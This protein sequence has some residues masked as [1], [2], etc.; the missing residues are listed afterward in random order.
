MILNC[1][2]YLLGVCVSYHNISLFNYLL[3]YH[4]SQ[5]DLNHQNSVGNTI[6]DLCA[7]LPND[8]TKDFLKPILEFEILIQISKINKIKLLMIFLIKK[9][10]III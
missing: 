8:L 9:N 7:K 3:T 4:T 6:L 2:N 5:F 10:K 1:N